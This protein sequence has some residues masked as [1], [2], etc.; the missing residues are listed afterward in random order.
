M[1]T[2]KLR[3]GAITLY[4]RGDSAN[5]YA[6]YK[7]QGGGRLQETLK[8]K[9]KA[10]AKERAQERYD[11]LKWRAKHGLPANTVTFSEAAD[12]WITELESQVAGGSRKPRSVIDYK[13]AIERYLKPYFIDRAV[14]GIKA[15]DI[16]K[17]RVWRRDYWIK[18]PGSSIKEITYIRGGI[19][20]KR[21]LTKKDRKAPAPRTYNGENVIMR[22]IFQHAVSQGWLLEHQIPKIDNAKQKKSDSRA[23]A[24]PHFELREYYGLKRFMSLWVT[25]N[26]LTEAERWRREAIQ[27]FLLILLNTGLREHELFKKDERTGERRGLRWSDI[28]PFTSAKGVDLVELHVT[29]K[30]GIRSVIGQRPVR[31]VLERRRKLRCP[32]HIDSD[33]VL[34]LP[35]GQ[36]P[37]GYDS[38]VKRL[39]EAAGLRIDPKTKRNR[40]I[41]SCR[42]SYATW[43]LQAGRNL[44]E[45]ANNMGTSPAM[46][47]QSYYHYRPR[48][49]ADSLTEGVA[50]VTHET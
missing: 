27:D 42:H 16:S 24:Y 12:A 26:D 50:P 35:D 5:W 28:S 43:R 1:A 29:G 36:M 49:I 11:D 48:T 3:D 18:G 25:S 7:L 17:Y 23:R 47:E 10:E 45:V 20:T 4:T 2:V 39:L 34:A 40:G 46:I 9:N 14:D 37:N 31:V 13:P 33:F 30:T 6:G 32:K 44:I 38:G 22:G 8:T 15:M 41:Y 21:T 19:K